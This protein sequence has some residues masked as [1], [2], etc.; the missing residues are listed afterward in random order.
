MKTDDDT[1]TMAPRPIN[2]ELTAR[3][4]ARECRQL[5]KRIEAMQAELVRVEGMRD[6]IIERAGLD[7]SK[8]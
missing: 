5:A 1:T 3:R 8:L 6:A 7:P 4:L 2:N